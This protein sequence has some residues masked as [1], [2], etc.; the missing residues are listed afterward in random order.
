MASECVLEDSRIPAREVGGPRNSRRA[1][2]CSASQRK[3]CTT[4]VIGR[5]RDQEGI[6]PRG[7]AAERQGQ[8]IV[9]G[10]EAGRSPTSGEND[11]GQVPNLPLVTQSG[12]PLIEL[13]RERERIAHLRRFRGAAAAVTTLHWT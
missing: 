10:E 5:I 7:R 13:G 3:R 4:I 6:E 1:Q 12:L 2:R 11:E 8:E 9:R